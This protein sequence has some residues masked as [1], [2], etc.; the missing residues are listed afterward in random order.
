MEY[1]KDAREQKKVRNT[2]SQGHKLFVYWAFIF[3]NCPVSGQ[4]YKFSKIDR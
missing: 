4:P 2:K 3:V 1:L